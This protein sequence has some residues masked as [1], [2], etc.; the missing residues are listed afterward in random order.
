MQIC[1]VCPDRE[2]A[3]AAVCVLE[4]CFARAHNSHKSAK[5][6]APLEKIV[7]RD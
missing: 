5:N 2:C 3:P 4:K 1:F 7:N 6:D